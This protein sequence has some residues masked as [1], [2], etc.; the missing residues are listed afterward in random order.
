MSELAHHM[1]T[2][3]KLLL[4]E[5]NRSLSSKEEL[6]YGSNG[7]L[8]IDL[9][10]GAFYDHENEEGGGVLDLIRRQK[11]LDNG[12][13][14]AWL[15]EQGILDDKGPARE[16]RRHIEATYDYVDEIGE[17]LFQ[18][19]RY[20]FKDARGNTMLEDGKPKKT[21]RQRRMIA[22]EWVWDVKGVR[23]VPYRLPELIEAIANERPVFIAEGEKCVDRLVAAGLP[24][25]CN[26]GGA[27][28]WKDELS[29]HFQGAKVVVLRDNDDAGRDH[30]Q[31]VAEKLQGIAEFALLLDLEGLPPKRDVYDWLEAGHT[32]EELYHLVETKAFKPAPPPRVRPTLREAYEKERAKKSDANPVAQAG[33]ALFDPW[34]RY[35]VPPFP[36]EILPPI[37]RDFVTSESELIGCVQGAL[38]MS[39][40]T[41]ISG[42]LDHRFALKIMRNGNWWAN[43]RLWVL[44]VGDS[45]IKK[46]PPI[47]AATEE[48]DRVQ[49]EA[50][51]QH[52]KALKDHLAA[53]GKK[54]TFGR[55]PPLRF[56]IYDTTIEKLGS[57]LAQQDRGTLVKRD[58]LAGWLG[59]MEKYGAGKG[60]LA[61]RAFWLKAYDGGPYT[62][63]RISRDSDHIANLSVSLIG[64]IQPARLGEIPGL[65]SDGLLQRFLPIMIT[66]S[67]FPVDTAFHTEAR[68]FAALIQQLLALRPQKLFLSDDAVA[69]MEKLRRYLHDLEQASGG[70]A[71]GFQSFVGKLPG[72]AGSLALILAFATDPARDSD[73]RVGADVIERVDVLIRDF[74]LP[75]AF[76]FYQTSFA[77]TERLQRIASWIL[78]SR[79]SRI[80]ASDFASNVADLKG[81]SQWE[82]NQRLSPL[83]AGG[84]LTANEP[85]PVARSW[86]VATRVFELFRARQEDEDRRKAAIK[87]LIKSA[88]TGGLG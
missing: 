80:V 79:K 40:M 22:G 18:V 72:V 44:L 61:D 66:R 45:S 29:P 14:A 69:A 60:S 19:V 43:P 36:L 33:V 51:A 71:D 7:S 25:T 38:A 5:P 65:A 17:P 39:A 6:R 10:K 20:G 70:L 53:G 9:Q 31:L 47:N 83:V 23:P 68:P 50:Q 78:T 86:T 12:E 54:K 27:K 35:V 2:V 73:A 76:E 15:R 55:D 41:A 85:G 28:K 16:E 1:E 48:L 24:A 58:E 81:L 4:G 74:I 52:Q 88:K 84:W 67:T 8:A 11:G 42:A 46:T 64:G 57:I 62:F 13:A 87:A 37:V 49:A 63:D 75:H 3:A 21:F 59:S 77:G 82:L 30:G 34:Q 56:I 32:V 26:V